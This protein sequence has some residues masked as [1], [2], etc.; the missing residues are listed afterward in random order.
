M[1]DVQATAITLL[2]FIV[3]S[4]LFGIATT[5]L[6]ADPTSPF[7]VVP[8]VVGIGLLVHAL[9][10]DNQRRIEITLLFLY[11]SLIS[12]LGVITAIRVS[13]LSLPSVVVSDT[14]IS[15]LLALIIVSVYFGQ[16]SGVQANRP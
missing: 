11:A 12:I 3:Y 14:I 8:L 16:D 5:L 15:V 6:L 2:K 9:Y 10:Y 13:S 7:R 1:S 4:V